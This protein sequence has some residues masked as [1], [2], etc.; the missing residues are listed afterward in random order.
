[1]LPYTAGGIALQD[2]LDQADLLEE[3]RPVEGRAEPQAGDGVADRD[4]AHRLGLVLGA[5]RILGASCP[6]SR[7]APPPRPGPG[8]TSG[9]YS[10]MRWSRRTT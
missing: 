8:D 3:E 5:N 6:G 7:G 1:M 2:L 4:L 9:P 10:R